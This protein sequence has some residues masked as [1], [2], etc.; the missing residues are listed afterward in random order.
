MISST[1]VNCTGSAGYSPDQK[2]AVN[3]HATADEIGHESRQSIVLALQPVVLDHYVLALDV[4]DF[5][6]AFAERSGLA[7][8]G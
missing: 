1:F 3:G 5:V 4:A 2:V 8:G 6:E 7:H